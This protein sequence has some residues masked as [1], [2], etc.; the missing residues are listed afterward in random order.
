MDSEFTTVNR[1]FVGSDD[2]VARE[3][4]F[5]PDPKSCLLTLEVM[6]SSGEG[7]CIGDTQGRS[8][9]RAYASVIAISRM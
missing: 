8:S 4:K 9:N 6:I 2:G 3:R 1:Y 7:V 5:R